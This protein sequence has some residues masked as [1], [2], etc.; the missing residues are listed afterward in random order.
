MSKHCNLTCVR[1]D[2]EQCLPISICNGY[3]ERL[4]EFSKTDASFAYYPPWKSWARTWPY[5][6]PTK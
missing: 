4:W 1:V 6:K 2:Y 3:F 5:S